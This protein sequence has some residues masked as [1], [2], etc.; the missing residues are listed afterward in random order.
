MV[1]IPERIVL[2]NTP[3]RIEKLVRWTEQLG[4]PNLYIKRDDYTG[5]EMSGNKIRKLEFSVQEALDQ[6]ADTLITC[7][8]SQSN[9]CRATAAV[10]AR[11]GLQCILVLRGNER[12]KADGN[13]LLDHLFGADV[14]FISTEDYAYRRKGIMEYAVEELR[15]HGRKGYVI[16]EGASN[17]IGGFGYFKA[18][19]EI[20]EQE[21]QLGVQ[22]DAIVSAT[23]SGGT[24]AGLLLG[25]GLLKRNVRNYA[26]NI[27]ADEIYFRNRISTV[28]DECA[29]YLAPSLHQKVMDLKEEIHILDGHAGLGYAISQEDEIEFIYKFAQTEGIVLDPVYTGKAFYGLTKEIQ[30][31]TFSHCKNVLFIHTGGMLGLFPQRELFGFDQKKTNW[32]RL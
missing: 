29:A 13:L 15:K 4:G 11:L 5:L 28:L 12:M 31:G 1:K 24:Y 26:V 10:A 8:G 30:K 25:S 20:I 18:M 21:K 7:G 2:A 32:K 23:G 3:T 27:S 16:P 17:G 6:G 22:F 19:E 9:H 14:R